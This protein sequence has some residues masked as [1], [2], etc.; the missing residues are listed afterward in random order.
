METVLR[1]IASKVGL[2]LECSR[3]PDR[4]RRVGGSSLWRALCPVPD[5]GREG[6]CPDQHN[7]AGGRTCL[8]HLFSFNAAVRF[9]TATGEM[10]RHNRTASRQL[11]SSK[12]LDSA[13]I[14]FMLGFSEI[15]CSKAGPR[16]TAQQV[17][18]TL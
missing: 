11:C 2:V 4:C 8:L 1:D 5:R 14:L 15:S 13:G 10:E 9:R 16:G 7:C 18:M 12:L 6:V 17:A 3:G